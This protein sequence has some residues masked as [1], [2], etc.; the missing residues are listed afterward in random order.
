DPG[1][2]HEAL[3]ATAAKKTERADIELDEEGNLIKAPVKKRRDE[4][5]DDETVY[6]RE[7]PEEAENFG[8]GDQPVRRATKESGD[9]G[10]GDDDGSLSGDAESQ[11]A[12]K[13]KVVVKKVRKKKRTA[14]Q[15]AG[16]FS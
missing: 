3:K 1:P 12:K 13:K 10:D 6:M 4:L 15:A 2:I 9:E 5:V 11:L 7:T 14:A 16:L 8:L